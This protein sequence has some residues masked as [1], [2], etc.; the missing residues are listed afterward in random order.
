MVKIEVEVDTLD[1]L[2]EVLAVGADAVLLDNMSPAQLRDAVGMVDGRMVTEASGGIT[3]ANLGEVAAAG[4]DIISLG[5]LTHSA[6][7]L[8]IGLDLE[9]LPAAPCRKS[10]SSLQP[11]VS[12][13][14]PVWFAGRRAERQQGRWRP[15]VTKPRRMAQKALTAVVQEAYVRGVSTRSI[16]ELV[17]DQLIWTSSG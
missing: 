10:S 16:D 9:P 6:P 7:I 8:D 2:R 1:Q 17:R 3:L 15:P 5:W 11:D 12:P 13:R 4:V 14:L